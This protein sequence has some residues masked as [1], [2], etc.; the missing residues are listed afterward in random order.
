MGELWELWRKTQVTTID[1]DTARRIGYVQV[2]WLN[3]VERSA[4]QRDSADSPFSATAWQK[5]LILLFRRL[6]TDD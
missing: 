3:A 2:S 6:A 5:A 1:P 4:L